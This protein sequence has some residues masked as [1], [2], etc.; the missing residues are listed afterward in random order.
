[1]AFV[2]VIAIVLP[3]KLDSPPLAVARFVVLSSK[4][5][6]EKMQRGQPLP[7]EK[8]NEMWEHFFVNQ[9][10]RYVAK[11]AGVSR[12]TV[13]R[14]ATLGDEARGIE[15]FWERYRRVVRE[16]HKLVERRIIYTDLEIKA[17]T[18]AQ[19]VLADRILAIAA[20]KLIEEVRT[21]KVTM[22][23]WAK[24]WGARNDTIRRMC[25]FDEVVTEETHERHGEFEGKSDLEY[26]FYADNDCR[27]PN[28]EELKELQ[29]AAEADAN[30]EPIDVE[31]E[32]QRWGAE[33]GDEVEE[34]G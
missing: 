33:D 24:L 13:K 3:G 9:S 2:I 6:V 7:L 20:Q 8:V 17:N 25:P 22:T 10:N 27:W 19:V 14:Y 26:G 4:A 15:P 30:G 31:A 32:H 18:Q 5:E 29:A 12:A 28:P 11:A 21:G 1:M 23:S 34:T 16:T